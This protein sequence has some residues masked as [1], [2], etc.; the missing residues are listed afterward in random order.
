MG[1]LDHYRSVWCVDSEFI[2]VPGGRPVPVC[3]VAR[4]L[5]TGR[6]VIPLPI[7]LPS[8]RA[9]HFVCPKR[10]TDA[11]QVRAFRQWI[12]DEAAAVDWKLVRG[13]KASGR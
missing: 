13:M 5:R 11:P 7:V 4:E 9:Y 12:K 1:W 6:L 3:V 10:R 2:I 8:G